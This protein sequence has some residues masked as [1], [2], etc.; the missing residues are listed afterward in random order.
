MNN[1]NK[2]ILANTDKTI[3]EF[4]KRISHLSH[5]QTSGIQANA[6]LLTPDPNLP[7]SNQISKTLIHNLPDN[8]VL[9][10]AYF[11][12]FMGLDARRALIKDDN[13]YCYSPKD[14]E[15]AAVSVFLSLQK[16]IE[17]YLS[18]GLKPPKQP[19]FVVINDPLELDNAYFDPERYEIHIGTGSGVKHRGLT[20]HIAFDLSVANH[21]FGHAVVSLQAPGGYLFGKLG[22]A[23]NEAIGDVLGA[24]V[25][26]YLDRI[27]YAKQLGRSF[28]ASDLKNDSRI[29]GKY[30]LPP[31]GIR[32]QKN[33]KKWPE[34]VVGEPHADGL[35]IGG[36]LADLLVAIATDG[37]MLEEQIKLF[38]KMTLMALTFLPSHKVT[39]TDMLRAL[40][41]AD[42]EICSGKYR[43]VIE[44]CFAY[45]GIVLDTTKISAKNILP[46]NLA[47]AR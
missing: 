21:E 46:K 24:L 15:F 2:I 20:K 4:S 28:D 5:K 27:W 33:S 18:L 42:K 17:L 29:I 9:K 39:F 36:A 19:M 22:L 25:M 34:D 13:T 16:Q 10:N 7:I 35:I 38:V 43:P 30:A 40:I 41:T 8:R 32:K 6:L 23:M 37:A 26:D 1:S 11:E 31:F 12:M 45:H 14:P 44:Q 47:V 3:N